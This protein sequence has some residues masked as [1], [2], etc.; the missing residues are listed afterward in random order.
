MKKFLSCLTVSVLLINIFSFQSFAMEN[1]ND[2]QANV[3]I[4]RSDSPNV[5]IVNSVYV[6][7]IVIY[8]ANVIVPNSIY[9]E[10]QLPNHYTT[11]TGTLY[12]LTEYIR[13]DRPN[14]IEAHYGGYLVGNL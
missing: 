3:S 4:I 9:W 11:S 13:S 12:Y 10:E 1:Y 8:P 7:R 6:E 14:E 5:R 2:W